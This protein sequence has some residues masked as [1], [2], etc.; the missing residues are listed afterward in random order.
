MP[1]PVPPSIAA[2]V[3]SISPPAHQVR[4]T[5]APAFCRAGGTGAGR[6]RGG[7][8]RR[9]AQMGASR[10]G[11]LFPHV[12]GT[13]PVAHGALGASLAAWRGRPCLSGACV[14]NEPGRDSHSPWR[15]PYCMRSMPKRAHGLTIRRCGWVSFR[16]QRHGQRPDL[17][18]KL[19]GL[20][21]PNPL[22]LAAGFDKNAEAADCRAAPGLRFRRGRDSDAEAAG[23]K[24]EATP[25]PAER[26]SRRSSI[27]WA[28]TMRAMSACACGCARPRPGIIGVN[29]GANKDSEDRVA[30]YVAGYRCF[31]ASC[32]LCDRQHLFAQHAGLAQSS[33]Q[34][35]T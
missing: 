3:S 12:Y 4:E 2:T 25:V 29:I 15:D 8:F 17:A 21:F 31:A 6:L 5:A 13:L 18:Q 1:L 16:M 28:S 22:G 9:H 10:G 23:G 26:R 7:R 35:R 30:D 33:G 34:G 24:S 27:A 19:F 20:T 11:E 14:A 32:R